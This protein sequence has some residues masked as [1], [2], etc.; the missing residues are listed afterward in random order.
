MLRS[1]RPS[2]LRLPARRFTA[3]IA[4]LPPTAR[5]AFGTD[6]DGAG[7]VAYNRSRA[8]TAT[9]IALYRSGYR[10]PLRDDELDDAVHALDFPYSRPSVE[11]RSAIRAALAVLEADYTVTVT[12]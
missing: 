12:H 1:L 5:E 10:L 6:I 11:T 4:A 2:R 9:A 3:G 7:A 8:A